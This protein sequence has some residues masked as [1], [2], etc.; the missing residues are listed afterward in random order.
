MKSNIKMSIDTD[1]L[2]QAMMDAAMNAAN[3]DGIDIECPNCHKQINVR[4]GECCP[5]CGI[6]INFVEGH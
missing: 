6:Q 3:N 1:K 2:K 4:T 5:F